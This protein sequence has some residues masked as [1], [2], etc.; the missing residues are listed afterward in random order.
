M[1]RIEACEL[2][3]E[4]TTCR[5][6]RKNQPNL[7]LRHTPGRKNGRGNVTDN[8]DNLIRRCSKGVAT[9]LNFS[10][11]EVVLGVEAHMPLR[12]HI[13]NGG[14]AP[15][16]KP[17]TRAAEQNEL[18]P[19]QDYRVRVMGEAELELLRVMAATQGGLK[20]ASKLDNREPCESW[21][22]DHQRQ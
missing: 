19:E 3:R 4:S 1:V 14:P 2:Q 22:C 21:F 11:L 5:F 7:T 12:P 10:A 15:S 9:P 8:F 16:R 18:T 6:A 17:G 13:A 20:L